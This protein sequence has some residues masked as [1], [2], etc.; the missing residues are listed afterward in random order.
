M[1]TLYGICGA[2]PFLFSV[3]CRGACRFF[4]TLI[5]LAF[6]II[7]VPQSSKAKR[8]SKVGSV[9]GEFPDGGV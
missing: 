7:D 3:E 8:P 9:Q 1:G 5:G 6:G 2:L 4:A